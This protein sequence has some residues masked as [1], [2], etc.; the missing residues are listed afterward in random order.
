MSG[1][2]PTKAQLRYLAE[3]R[4]GLPGTRAYTPHEKRMY[5]K[6][7]D[8]G[9]IE[10]VRSAGAIVYFAKTEAGRAAASSLPYHNLTAF[11][12]VSGKPPLFPHAPSSA[13]LP[14]CTDEPYPPRS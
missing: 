14:P 7:Q 13:P 10:P 11:A 9:W 5:P 3:V 8:A 2:K 1:T 4:D 12:R 6:L